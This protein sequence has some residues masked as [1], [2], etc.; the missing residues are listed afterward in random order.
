MIPHIHPDG[1]PTPTARELYEMKDGLA[2][3][4][5]FNRNMEPTRFRLTDKGHAHLGEIMRWNAMDTL[6]RG[7]S[8]EEGVARQVRARSQKG[9]GT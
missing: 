3:A 8:R 1:E 5:D 6:D 2:E 9:S 4:V 7:T